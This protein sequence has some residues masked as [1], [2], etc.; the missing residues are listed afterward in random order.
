V[1]WKIDVASGTKTVF[2][3]VQYGAVG[4]ILGRVPSPVVSCYNSAGTYL[5]FTVYRGLFVITLS[6]PG[7]PASI[8]TTVAGYTMYSTPALY[9]NYSLNGQ[10]YLFT[11]QCGVIGTSNTGWCYWLSGITCFLASGQNDIVPPDYG[12][13]NSTAPP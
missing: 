13:N 1:V 5:Y 10:E 6:A 7:I 8:L 3:D 4:P 9:Q 2:A 12:N 11:T